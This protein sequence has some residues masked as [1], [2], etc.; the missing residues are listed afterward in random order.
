MALKSEWGNVLEIRTQRYARTYF[1]RAESAE[2]RDEWGQAI[3]QA[4]KHAAQRREAQSS[5]SMRHKTKL[6][7]RRFVDSSWFQNIISLLLVANFVMNVY[8]SETMHE[9]G[10]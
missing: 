1:L 4:I 6:R 2:E 10:T 7:V 3:K 9:E 8:D 5:K